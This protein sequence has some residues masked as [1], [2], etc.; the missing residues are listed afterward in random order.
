M[1]RKVLIAN[2]GEIALR[3]GRTLRRMGIASVAIYSDADRFTAPVLAADEAV[4]I[5]RS[6]AAESYLRIEAIIE[7]CRATGAEAVHPGYGFL[8]ERAEFVDALDAAGIRF[9][10]PRAEH[11]RAFGLKHSARALAERAGV[12][13]LPGSGLLED[14]AQAVGAAATIGFPVMLKSTAGG[15]GIGMQLCRNEAELIER[16]ETVRRQGAN[17]FGDA[18][19]YLEK[20]VARAR[21]IE[22]QV[23]GDGRGGVV[24]LGERDCSLQRRNQKVIEETPAPNLPD[25]TRRMLHAASRDLAAA[26]AYESAGTVEFVYDADA[27][28]AYFLE[29]NTRL[30]VEHGV[31]EAVFDVDLVEWML[32]Q[33]AGE[34]SLPPQHSLQ[35][36]GV[37]IEA[38]VYAE[39]AAQGFR[40][41]TGRLTE[42]RF[43]A[44]VRID[45]WIETGA[46]V[47]PYYDPLLAKII[48]HAADRP[49]AIAQL[50]AAVE[51]SVIFGLESNLDHLSA[52]L[53]TPALHDAS[54]TTATL[55][56]L[57][58][59][60][61]SIEVL[62]PGT[63]STVQDW[64]GRIG[65]WDVGVPPSGPMDDRSHRAANRIVGNSDR[66]ATLEMTLTGATLRF[67]APAVIALAG[68]AMAATLDGVPV[69]VHA[70]TTVQASQ[71]LQMGGIEGLGM[72]CYLAVRGGLDA[73]LFLGSRATFTLGG[74]GGHA[75]GA[76]RTGDVLRMGDDPG[77]PADLPKPAPLTADWRIGVL[78][79]PHGA[80]DFF[81]PADVADLFSAS[82]AVHYNSART[83]IRLIGPT[84]RWARPDGGEAGLH[85]SNIH[86][87]PYAIGSIDFTGDMPILL[88]PD[89]P[90]LGGFVCPAVV[91]DDELWKLGQL[92]PG[93]RVRFER[94]V[95]QKLGLRSLA[96]PDLQIPCDDGDAVLLRRAGEVPVVYRR[97]GDANL[98]V[99]YGPL[100]LDIRLRLRVQLLLSAIRAA[101]LPGLIDLTP[102]IRSLQVHY[103]PAALSLSRLLDALL[104]IERELPQDDE[105]RVPS[106][107]VH[108]PL[109]WD[110]DQAR[111]AMSRYQELVRPDA[112]WCPSNI[113]FIRR[114]N[115]LGSIDDVRRIVFDAS[116]LVLG[117]G[118]VYLGAPVAT[119]VDPRH[120]LV[121]T[122]YNPARTWTPENAVGIGGSYL[123][124][125]GMEGPGGYQLFG[126]TLQV[127]N[128]W[129]ST[130][131]FAP[132]KPWLLRFFDQIRFY[133][134]SP[135]ELLEARAA[136][137]HGRHPLRIEDSSFSSGDYTRF[138][139]ANAP[140]I[141]AARA[142]Q[143]AAFEA[144]RQDW[145]ARGLDRFVEDSGGDVLQPLAL[146]SGCVAL[147]SPMPG[148]VW[149]ILVGEGE[150]VR[151]GDP[152]VVI[153]SM[154]TE[155]QL[156]S[157]ASGQVRE[158]P[159]RPGREVRAGQRIL[160]IQT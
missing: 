149:K 140:G 66:A 7:A 153:E 9:I 159:C 87:T 101:R 51:G 23:F 56:G 85:P 107:I 106:R 31:T 103:D 147:E 119:P 12:P 71:T 30:Q 21:H 121:T 117:L 151:R 50:A 132:G 54:M 58:F 100:V 102:G 70:A 52:I 145:V 142:R 73:P 59:A 26:A 43:P 47:T 17:S 38:R 74:F 40:P 5:G 3:I 81:D 144:E 37:A 157:P 53:A 55:A 62:A 135:T 148:N 80:P 158:L 113:E 97:A 98:L 75:T 34:L 99:E 63:Q 8:S 60:P 6:P 115:G 67:N 136:F 48:A 76:L 42:V 154:K 141:A 57:A 146:P 64:P 79:G 124:I 126:R 77:G 120:R 27:G 137:P 134:V 13:L 68:A 20:F 69:A 90:S 4:A 152:V 91:A 49:A 109:S 127:W 78:Y 130:G 61:R 156:D 105:T 93:D 131:P 160:V 114:I 104:Q 18:R 92:R 128:S 19:V 46:E 72:R 129:R 11:L 45:G 25:A 123:C 2:R 33:A 125:Y 86:D 29:V 41:S 94:R 39:N 10:G 133:P 122:K 139:Q 95:P 111:L 28:Q 35:P 138:E 116:Y 1:F 36:Q 89:G 84:P 118:D 14:L 108:L 150:T 24:T 88:G 112:P 143:Q 83:G 155:I 16:F 15:G 96:A 44:G 110:D 32:L 82:Y 22:V 65:F